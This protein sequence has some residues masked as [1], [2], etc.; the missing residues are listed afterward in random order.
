MAG[1]PVLPKRILAASVCLLIIVSFTFA[2]SKNKEAA[3]LIEHAKQLSNI[4]AEHSGAFVLQAN[5]KIV[6]DPD[7]PVL[8]S[9]I[10]TWAS[11]ALLRTEVSAGDFHSTKVINDR[12]RWELSNASETP[13]DISST[14]GWIGYR[15]DHLSLDSRGPAKI[16]DRTSGSWALRCIVGHDDGFGGRQELCFDK[17]GGQLVA[18]AVPF[19]S[20][21][22][23]LVTRCAFTD[24]QKLGNTLFP[25]SIQCFE[26]ERQVLDAR[27]VQLT[28][29]EAIDKA[30]FAAI[31][32]AKEFP[33]CPVQLK[34][35]EAIDRPESSRVGGGP[36]VISLI[37]GTDGRP[38]D[39]KVY[40]SADA[41]TDEAALEAVRRWRFKPATCEGQPMETSAMVAVTSHSQ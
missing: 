35:P 14:V 11:P 16:I 13:K 40:T 28:F 20:Q 23:E 26:G 15:M 6:R 39:L 19:I 5:F 37:V 31:P 29:Q 34:N 8:G 38:Y 27:V 9:Y 7:H 1:T 18:E 36:V 3:T 22:G 12:K 24:F 25:K 4:R 21:G 33:N 10:E 32:G 41:E 2:E 17:S 30:I